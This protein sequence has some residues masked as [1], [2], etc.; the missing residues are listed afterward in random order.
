MS[1]IRLMSLPA[2]AVCALM[3]IP[4]IA[5]ADGPRGGG[6]REARGG[7]DVS[8]RVATRIRRSV[9]ALDRAEERIDDGENARAIAQLKASRRYL[10]AALKAAQKRDDDSLEAVGRAQHRT[11]ETVVGLFDGVT[12]ADVVAALDATLD[13][14]IAGRVA[15]PADA[16]AD[17]R[18]A[19][20]DAL[21]DDELTD[22]ARA[23]L[24]DADG[25]LQ[26]TTTAVA[27]EEGADYPGGEGDGPPRRDGRCRDRG[28]DDHPSGPGPG[29]SGPTEF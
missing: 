28:G 19:I 25:A 7:G 24:T 29:G 16:I 22:G 1:R 21:A 10:A 20:A 11:I 23:S 9:R 12:D 14:A 27:D 18:E 4:A 2:L 15:A 17:E 13:A 3:A 8:S 26:A 5:S 6:E